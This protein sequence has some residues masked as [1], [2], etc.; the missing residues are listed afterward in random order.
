MKEY[1][2]AN[3]K[4]IAMI[5]MF[6]DHIGAIIIEKSYLYHASEG[7][8]ILDIILRQIGRLSFPLYCFLLV[9]AFLH[10]R[11]R[12]NYAIRVLLLA[13][14]SEIQ[15]DMAF[16]LGWNTGRQNVLFTLFLG[17]I[18]IQ[19]L[20]KLEEKFAGI[21]F[22]LISAIP[23]TI[24]CILAYILNSS[25]TYKGILL[26]TVLYLFR[27]DNKTKCILGAIIMSQTVAAIVS[28]IFMYKYNGQKGENRIPNWIYQIFYPVHILILWGVRCLII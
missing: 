10:T 8:Q 3:L 6:I 20:S 4:I 15:Y 13:F 14:L 5:T 16:S 23:I 7:W 27:R 21:S 11:N 17:F 12:K 26:I 24:T 18:L 28:F 19:I 9:E 1:N 25:Y 22:Y 2:G